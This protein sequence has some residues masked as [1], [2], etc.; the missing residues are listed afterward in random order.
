MCLRPSGSTASAAR[1]SQQIAIAVKAAVAD[2]DDGL[3]EP[4]AVINLSDTAL[5]S[6]RSSITS[7]SSIVRESYE[8]LETLPEVRLANNAAAKKGVS[9]GTLVRLAGP[10]VCSGSKQEAE[11]VCRGSIVLFLVFCLACGCF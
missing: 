2:S 5:G 8:S 11:T 3:Q 1:E 9:P 4:D 10:I 7:G 6:A